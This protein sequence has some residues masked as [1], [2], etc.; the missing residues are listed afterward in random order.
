[1]PRNETFLLQ[2]PISIMDQRSG[3]HYSYI[4]ARP[5]L[6]TPSSGGPPIHGIGV[7]GAIL[8]SNLHERS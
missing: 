1:M 3:V 5:T 6:P 4:V 7:G 8:L 2:I